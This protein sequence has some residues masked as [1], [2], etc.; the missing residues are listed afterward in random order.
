[1][2]VM[3]CDA[4]FISLDVDM[5]KAEWGQGNRTGGVKM[6]KTREHANKRSH[7]REGRSVKGKLKTH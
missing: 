7:Q 1:M 4:L 2:F 3:C 6:G 5:E